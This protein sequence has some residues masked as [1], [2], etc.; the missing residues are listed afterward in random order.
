MCILTINSAELFLFA[1]EVELVVGGKETHCTELS[2]FLPIIIARH[3]V[4]I[5]FT[6][7][8]QISKAVNITVRLLNSV[9]VRHKIINVVFNLIPISAD[10]LYRCSD[11]ANVFLV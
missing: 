8:S 11:Q 7:N 3:H 1:S 4:I 9:D 2:V 10:E 6:R 5:Y